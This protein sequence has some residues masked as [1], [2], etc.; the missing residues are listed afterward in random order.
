MKITR[1]YADENGESHFEDI[2]IPLKNGGEIGSLSEVIPVIGMML[3]ENPGDYNYDWHPAPRKQYI[4]MLEGMLEIMVSDGEQRSFPPGEI[5]FVEDTTGKGHKS[6][7]PD[8]RPRKSL[9]IT[10]VDE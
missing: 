2:D 10:V 7:V 4:V 8:G 5:L 3:R 1:L 9:F 6:W